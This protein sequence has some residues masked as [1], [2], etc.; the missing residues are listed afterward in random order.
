LALTRPIYNLRSFPVPAGDYT[1]EV[2]AAGIFLFAP[3]SLH[4][5]PYHQPR[6]IAM[7]V[8]EKLAP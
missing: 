3:I 4:P 7:T 1:L 5:F 8:I 2:I 6:A